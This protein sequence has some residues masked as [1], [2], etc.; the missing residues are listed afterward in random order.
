MKDGKK[1]QQRRCSVEGCNKKHFGKGLCSMHY[2]RFIKKEIIGGAGTERYFLSFTRPDELK[3]FLLEH[4]NIKENGCWE[5]TLGTNGGY[6]I[7]RIS[8]KAMKVHRISAIL[9]LGLGINSKLQA[10]HYCD[11]PPC[12]NPNHLFIG[13][14]ADNMHDM[15]NKNYMK[16]VNNWRAKLTNQ[17]VKRIKLMLSMGENY[18]NISKFFNV[19]HSAIWSILKNKSWKH[20][21]AQ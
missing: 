10:L 2:Q 8:G 5:W 9:Y 6:G 17:K 15:A 11:N 13:T 1:I 16:G 19:S 7:K 20:V 14:H 3:N 12:F 4:R 18:K 21:K